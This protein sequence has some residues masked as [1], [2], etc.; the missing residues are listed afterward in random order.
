MHPRRKAMLRQQRNAQPFRKRAVS[1][2]QARIY[3]AG[4]SSRRLVSVFV[5]AAVLFLAVLAR[6]TLLQTVQAGALRTAGK[7]QRT[8]EQRLKA[9]RGTIFDRDGADLALS[10]PARTV[11]ANPKLVLDAAGTVRTL[12][13]LLHLDPA[14]QQSL[15]TAFTAKKNSFVYVARQ[16][17]PNL[18]DTVV[19][20][21][22]AGV[23]AINEDKREVPSGDVGR[24]VIGRTDPDLE[25]TGGL[26]KEYNDILRGVDGEE[27]Q[28]HDRKYR[29][30][31]GGDETVAPIPGSDVVL[32]LDRGLQYQVEKALL[33]RVDSLSAVGG[34]AIVM[35]VNSGDIYSVANVRRDADGKVKVTSANLAATEP[36]EPG[37]VAKVFSLSAAVNEG[38]ATP[39]TTIN[40]PGFL[41]Y[42]PVNK[43]DEKWKFKIRDAEPHNDEAMSL[44]D[45]IVHSSNIGTVLIT[46]GLG[47]LKFGDYLH[48]FGFG[49]TTGLGL[50]DESSG[51]MKPAADWQATE[52][53]TPRY[54]YGYAATSLQLAAAV[55]TIANHGTYVAPR[56]VLSTIDAQGQTHNAP[57]SPSHEVVTP[58]TATTMTSMMKDVVCYGTAIYAKVPGMSVAGKTGTALLKPT[59]DPAQKQ[60]IAAAD[61]AATATTTTAA[62]TGEANPA[63]GTDYQAND[64]SKEYYSTFVGYF[65]AD[66]PQVTILVS[67]D[68][69]DP[70]NQDRLGGKAAGPLFSTL[71]TIANH[72]TYVAPRLVLS[73][74]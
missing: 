1:Q 73:T 49:S 24:S 59:V 50:P 39:E 23:S 60:A 27:S 12:T 4:Q 7:D 19:A 68:R 56:L 67:I 28:E 21:R 70:T 43:S 33:Q 17:D 65:P 62:P 48:Q 61:N 72:G 55:N 63:A 42:R 37:S 47:T 30:I 13:A 69:P 66:N 44:R 53:V 54:G 64:G 25:G 51:I 11:T 36:H 35:G 6:V 57:P 32:T 40:V 10:V 71:A 52:K 58:A 9:H 18:A 22:L 31:A 15:L 45:I 14:K 46:E 41:V 26:E 3:K 2:R 38:L 29:S 34:T 5:I 8:T 16:I 74:I 20:L